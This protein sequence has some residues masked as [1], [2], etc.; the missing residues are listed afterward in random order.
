MAEFSEQLLGWSRARRFVVVRER[1]REGRA[2]V[3][4]KLLEVPGYTHRVFVTSFPAAP[5]VIWRDYNQR[6]TLEQRI[7]KLKADLGAD[8]FCLREFY[9][10]EAAFRAVLVLFNLLSLW[11]RAARPNQTY[12]R[13]A[14]LRTEVF[15]CGA[16]AGR[17]GPHPRAAFEPRLG[18][19]RTTHA[20]DRERLPLLPRNPAAIAPTNR[21]PPSHATQLTLR[22]PHR[23]NL[24][25]GIRV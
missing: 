10:T 12:R 19:A 20:P 1:V 18:R 5:E 17:T 16:I 3:G 4:R 24:N 22:K 21:K 7:D 14:T 8:D 2:A 25:R 6:A 9:A 11:Q 15:L 13:P 23:V